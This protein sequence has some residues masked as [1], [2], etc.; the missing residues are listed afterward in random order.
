MASELAL[1]LKPHQSLPVGRTCA[2]LVR[3][4]GR[5]RGRAYLAWRYGGNCK[6]PPLPR[7]A[8]WSLYL[9]TRRPASA[10]CPTLEECDSRQPILGSNTALRK[11]ALYNLNS[12]GAPNPSL[13]QTAVGAAER[14]TAECL[15]TNASDARSN[16]NPSF[17][18]SNDLRGLYNNF[19][20]RIL[21][22]SS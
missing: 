7:A 3:L 6:P 2:P 5:V 16:P 20:Y 9:R 17:Q 13:Q 4:Q 10:V 15:H 19:W 22:K 1:Y 8:Q 12:R 14:D 18:P 21:H 11:Q